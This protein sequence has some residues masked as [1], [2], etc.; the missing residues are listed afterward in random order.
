VRSWII[1]AAALGLCCGGGSPSPAASP[2]EEPGCVVEVEHPGGRLAIAGV[3]IADLGPESVQAA[4][5]A[6]DRI[7]RSEWS[8]GTGSRMHGRIT[9][10]DLHHV[11]DDVGIV[12]RTSRVRNQDDPR[13]TVLRVYL[14]EPRASPGIEP[15]VLPAQL[16]G[17]RVEINGVHVDPDVD[18][19]APRGA[20]D[21]DVVERF[22]THFVD[23]IERLYTRED[24]RRLILHVDARTGRPWLVEIY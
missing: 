23:S 2:F 15:E 19:G 18:L 12:L 11:H 21:G 8:H 7:V 14:A 1:G 4:L 13:R 16:G 10:V 20:E 24:T 9:I 22:G 6:P 3:E 5:G 17:C